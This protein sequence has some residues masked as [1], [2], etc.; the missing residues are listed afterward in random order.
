MAT[1][2]HELVGQVGQI[3]EDLGSEERDDLGPELFEV[4][5]TLRTAERR[6]NRALDR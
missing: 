2:L 3:A 1:R 6:L 5:R 4:E